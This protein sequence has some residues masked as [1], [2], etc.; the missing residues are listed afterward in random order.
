MEDEAGYDWA[1]FERRAGRRPQDDGD[2]PRPPRPRPRTAT[3]VLAGMLGV[4][5][6]MLEGRER[7]RPEV[8]RAADDSGEPDDEPL[9]VHLDPHDA[10]RSVATFRPW[11]RRGR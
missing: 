11:L 4:V 3:V 7:R 2:R 6:D 1:A 8:V 10:S 5:Q 9:L